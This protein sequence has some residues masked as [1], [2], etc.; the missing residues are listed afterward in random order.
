MR[1]PYGKTK[2]LAD[3]YTATARNLQ[4]NIMKEFWDENRKAFVNGVYRNGKPDNRISHHAQYWAILTGLFPEQHIDN[5]FANILPNIPYYYDDISYEKGYEMLAY[6][7]AGK[8]KEMW[9]YLSRT[10]GDWKAKGHSRFPENLSPNA[11]RDSQ[12]VFY[13]RPYGLSLCHG[14]NGAPIVVGILNGIIGFS[15]SETLP[16]TYMFNPELLH[17]NYI[18]ASIPVKEGVISLNLNREGKSTITIPSDC[19][20]RICGKTFNKKGTYSFSLCKH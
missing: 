13:G 10:F 19:R 7:K 4:N 5:L 16:S 9:N 3:K 2:K 1:A 15:Q 11:P 8:V 17:L 20:I 14:A 18:Q 6:S 12:L